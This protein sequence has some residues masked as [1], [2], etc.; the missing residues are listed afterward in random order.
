MHRRY[1]MRKTKALKRFL[2]VMLAAVMVFGVTLPAF[3]KGS[4]PTV[5]RM[6]IVSYYKNAASTGHAWLYFEN[7]SKKTVTVGVYKLKPGDGISVGT[8][9]YIRKEG[10]GV[11]YNLESYITNHQGTKGRV[12]LS[13]DITAAQLKK[14]SKKINQFK[15]KWNVAQN[16]TYFAEKVWNTVAT[17][18]L[19]TAA[20]PLALRNAIRRQAGCEKNLFHQSVAAKQVFKQK[21][22]SL[23][24]VRSSA[25]K[26][27]L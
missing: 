17:V 26:A 14:V 21:G 1:N 19:N 12:S 11:Y 16:C 9:G 15:S 25:L 7:T 20:T 22:S 23:K 27:G 6:S 24:R 3:A 13:Q 8:F 10:P 2:C 5:V 4:S 18:K